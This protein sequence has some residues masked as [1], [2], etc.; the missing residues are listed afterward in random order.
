MFMIIINENEKFFS[1]KNGPADF[2]KEF[3]LLLLFH[4]FYIKRRKKR[5]TALTVV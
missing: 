2:I 3:C 4:L 5:Y 1:M